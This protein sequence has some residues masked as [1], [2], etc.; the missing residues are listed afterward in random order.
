MAPLTR[1]QTWKLKLVRKTKPLYLAKSCIRLGSTGFRQKA[2]SIQPLPMQSGS[3]VPVVSL[4][5]FHRAHIFFT[6][7]K[8]LIVIIG[9]SFVYTE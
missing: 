1:V 5:C 4:P 3:G 8:I 6:V 7:T 2:N 9:I